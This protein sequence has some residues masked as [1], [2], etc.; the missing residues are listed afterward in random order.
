M[1]PG[2]RVDI[3]PQM[4]TWLTGRLRYKETTWISQFPIIKY[5]GTIDDVIVLLNRTIFWSQSWHFYDRFV[6]ESM[7]LYIIMLFSNPIYNPN[8]NPHKLHDNSGKLWLKHN[9]CAKLK[10]TYDRTSQRGVPFCRGRFQ[11]LP[12]VTRRQGPKGRGMNMTGIWPLSAP[13]ALCHTL[14]SVTH[15]KI[16]S[17]TRKINSLPPEAVFISSC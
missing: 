10:A 5:T 6:H 4:P 14:I 2:V 13:F 15:I 1:V 3:N 16:Q 11:P 7:F 9:A 17:N 8:P 12:R